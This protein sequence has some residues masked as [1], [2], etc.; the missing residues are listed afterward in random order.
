MNGEIM[1]NEL[2][3]ILDVVSS[4]GVNTIVIEPN[5]EGGSRIRGRDKSSQ[6]LILDNI[7]DRICEYPIGVGRVDILKSR[8]KLFSPDAGGEVFLS[9]QDNAG[10]VS[11]IDIKQGRKKSSYHCSNIRAL[12]TPSLI[13]G[14]TSVTEDNAITIT[15]EYGQALCKAL[16]SIM[17]GF[18]DEMAYVQFNKEPDS[19]EI[20][21]NIYDGLSDNFTDIIPDASTK[22]AC[23]HSWSIVQ[24]RTVL[25]EALR[26]NTPIAL[27]ISEIGSLIV[28]I[29]GFINVLIAPN[30]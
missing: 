4:V 19:T 15:P 20:S 18:N 10:V 9:F 26:Q 5:E 30:L 11:K 29:G 23:S 24:F 16:E 3:T 2:M 6:I 21:V 22:L 17:I 12:G 28:P 7:P 27:G 1:Y 13:P 25:K 14:G 8:L